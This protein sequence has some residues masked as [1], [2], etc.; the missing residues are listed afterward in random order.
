MTR[1]LGIL[2]Y[3]VILTQAVPAEAGLV[4]NIPNQTLAPGTSI[5]SIVTISGST[6]DLNSIIGIN[7]IL[8][9]TPDKA[10]V[11]TPV[12]SLEFVGPVDAAHDPTLND[13]H[14]LLFGQSSDAD[15]PAT[16]FAT[17]SS[18]PGSGGFF[19]R[20]NGNDS[21]DGTPITLTNTI[22]DLA[23][24]QLT[25]KA[26]GTTNLGGDLFDISLD[27]S[28]TYDTTTATGL[29]F[30]NDP[31]T[32]QPPRGQVLVTPLTAVPEP[33]IL[34][35]GLITF[36]SVLAYNLRLRRKVCRVSLGATGHRFSV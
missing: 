20:F 29:S 25:Y 16:P 7:L 34:P 21:S 17:V 27:P 30:P 3:L 4:V 18:P 1:T 5:S 32:H 26:S 12:A 28:S 11:L 22:Y 23:V 19:T 15:P 9:I 2:A 6:S 13:V 14:Y 8:D 36:S 33:G 10:N 31:I 35:L 24:L